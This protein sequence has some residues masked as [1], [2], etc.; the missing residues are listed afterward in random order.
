MIVRLPRLENRPEAAT[1]GIREQIP[2]KKLSTTIPRLLKKV[3][4]WMESHDVAPKG[5]PFLRFH[6]IDMETQF[7]IEVGFPVAGGA[8]GEGDIIAGVLPPGEYATLVY[9]G[10]PGAT[11][12]T[13]P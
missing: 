8:K 13:R 10:R 4:A 3:S 7:D 11:R 6:V 5:A 12:A 2:P 9:M 1:L